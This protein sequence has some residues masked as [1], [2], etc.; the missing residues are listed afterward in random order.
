MEDLG[1]CHEHIAIVSYI[2]KFNYK[3]ECVHLNTI[4]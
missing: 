2:K 1:N 4:D 3:G